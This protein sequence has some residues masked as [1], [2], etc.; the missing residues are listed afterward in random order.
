MTEWLGLAIVTTMGN[1][2]TPLSG[3]LLFRATYL[4]HQHS[5]SFTKFATFLSANYLINFWVIGVMG[6]L[7]IFLINPVETNRLVLLFFLLVVFII[8]AIFF[9]PFSKMPGHSR[10][11]KIINTS[12][13]GWLYIKQDRNLLIRL[14]FYT[15]INIL[16]NASSFWIASNALG[17]TIS[18]FSSVMISLIAAFSIVIKLTPAN[19]GIHEAIIGFTSPL[20][21]I[22]VGEGLMTALVLR[23]AGMIILFFLGP[24]FSYILAKKLSNFYKDKNNKPINL[25]S[26]NSI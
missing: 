11:I 14:I 4:K 15:L 13:D 23:G 21:G 24:I 25:S 1:Y 26:K 2:L 19:L 12:I 16:L 10:F 7:T 3:G 9:L 6:V 22:G 18:A 20:V 5:F 17:F 8:S